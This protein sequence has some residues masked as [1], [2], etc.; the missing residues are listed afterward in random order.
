MSYHWASL[1]GV[2]LH[3]LHFLHKFLWVI[4]FSESASPHLWPSYLSKHF[5]AFSCSSTKLFSVPDFSPSLRV[6]GLLNICLLDIFIRKDW[7]K[8]S[9]KFILFRKVY[10]SKAVFSFVEKYVFYML[11]QLSF[12]ICLY[13]PGIL[14]DIIKLKRSFILLVNIKWNYFCQFSVCYE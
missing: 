13:V 12:P 11:F 3:L 9:N 5:L 2:W 6:T 14:Y 1:R 4:S 8:E 10:W 7:G